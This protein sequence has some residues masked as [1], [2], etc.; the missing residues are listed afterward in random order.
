MKSAGETRNGRLTPMQNAIIGAM[1][2]LA[3]LRYFPSDELTR[4]GIMRL[5]ERMA[6]TPE[7][8]VELVRRTV[9]HYNDWPGPLEL[10]GVFCTFAKPR[11]GVEAGVTELGRLEAAIEMRA[12]EAHDA[13]KHLPAPAQTMRLLGE[14]RGGE[15]RS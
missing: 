9:A 8:V 3:M 5:I 13:V 10:R 1:A 7:Q 11:D 15:W 6:S 2:D 14:A 12:I 4:T